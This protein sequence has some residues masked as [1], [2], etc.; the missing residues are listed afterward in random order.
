MSLRLIPTTITAA[1]EYVRLHH[2]HNRPPVSG[3]YAVACEDGGALVG[4]AIVGRPVARMLQDGLTVEITRCCTDGTRN[5][6]SFLYGAAR[7]VAQALGYTRC[8]TY[9][10]QSEPG[11]SLRA[12]GWKEA[13][14]RTR[15]DAW[16]TPSRPRRPG[17]VDGQ[18]KIRWEAHAQERARG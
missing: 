7:R 16:S 3:L 1:K 6:A 2:R 11:S 4:V 13:A 8:V 9:T 18:S 17:T 15:T 10:L 14:R 12:A 5:A